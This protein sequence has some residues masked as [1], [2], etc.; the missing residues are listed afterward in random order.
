MLKRNMQAQKD[1][2]GKV[3]LSTFCYKILKYSK[4]GKR[5]STNAYEPTAPLFNSL[6]PKLY[7]K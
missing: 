4:V 7:Q 1:S 2:R 6:L 3:L 5:L